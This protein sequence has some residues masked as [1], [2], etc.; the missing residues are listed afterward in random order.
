MEFSRQEHW[1]GLPCPLPDD[2]PNPGVKPKSPTLEA[3]SLLS[4]PPGKP[5]ITN[6]FSLLLVCSHYLCSC[7]FCLSIYYLFPQHL[8]SQMTL[9]D[10]M[11]VFQSRVS[12]DVKKWTIQVQLKQLVKAY[13][14][15]KSW[16]QL[17]KE[18]SIY[19]TSWTLESQ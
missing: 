5:K 18:F 12:A 2:L 9:P 7:T 11:A 10:C 19:Q 4:V 14:S 17:S 6:N 16:C 1:N 13:S 15:R 8:Y 3:D